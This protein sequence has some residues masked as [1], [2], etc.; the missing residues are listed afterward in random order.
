MRVRY[1]ST[2]LP[3]NRAARIVDLACGSGAYLFN[4]RTLGYTNVSGVDVSPEQINLAHELGITEAKCRDLLQELEELDSESVDAILMI[5]IL[6]HLE[7]EELFETLDQ[8]FRVL[9]RGGVCLAH[10]PNGEGVHGMRVRYGDLTHE[11]AFTPQST[12]QLFRTVGFREVRCFEERPFVHGIK[13][14][15][16]RILWVVGTIPHRL[17]LIAETGGAAFTLSQNMIV[18][19]RK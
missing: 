9:N 18:S 4:L 8:V 5:D 12:Q 14:F 7:M 1:I 11:R 6:E 19:A 15:A 13:S 17:L 16:R 2:Y 10:V 3:E